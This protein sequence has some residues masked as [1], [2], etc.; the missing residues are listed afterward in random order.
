MD[1]KHLCDLHALHTIQSQ[2]YVMK[3]YGWGSPVGLSIFFWTL[4]GIASVI[5][6]VFIG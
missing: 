3:W 2:E 1:T 4:I 6:I 5:K